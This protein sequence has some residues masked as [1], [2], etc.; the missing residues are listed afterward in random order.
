M[1][2][3]T[4]HVRDSA[5]V[6]AVIVVFVGAGGHAQ[7]TQGLADLSIQHLMNIEVTSVSRKAQEVA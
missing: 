4:G 3:S 6:A 7:Q 2:S 5:P 1:K